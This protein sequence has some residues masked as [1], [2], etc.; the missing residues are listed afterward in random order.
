MSNLKLG[1][2]EVCNHTG[3]YRPLIYDF[4]DTGFLKG[5]QGEVEAAGG[6]LIHKG[7]AGSAV[8]DECVG[9]DRFGSFT[10]ELQATIK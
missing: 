6:V 9:G 10:G 4:Q 7:K 1:A 5:Y 2:K 3:G 8:V